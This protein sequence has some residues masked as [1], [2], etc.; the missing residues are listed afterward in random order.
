MLSVISCDVHESIIRAC[1]DRSF[2]YRRFGQRKNRVVIF[3]RSDVVCEGAATRLLFAFIVTGKIA[4]DLGPALSVI[5]RFE[6]AFGSRIE[7]VRVVR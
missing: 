3:D 7:H 6:N 5:G 4:A 1:P 2:F